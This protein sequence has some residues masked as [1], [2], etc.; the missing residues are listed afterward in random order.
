MFSN[1][2]VA[3]ILINSL[4]F[5]CEHQ[6]ITLFAYVIMENHLHLIASAADL[7]GEIAKFKSFT[8]RKCIDC[9]SEEKNTFILDQLAQNKLKHKRDRSYQ[10]WQEGSHPQRMESHEVMAQKVDYIHANPVRRGY[11]DQAEDWRYSSAKD[12]AGK[13]G[14]LPISMEW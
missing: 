9:Y 4:Q 10:L 8:A 6:R 11:V 7:S 2:N 13:V 5:L 3:S 12:Y 14:L 1:A